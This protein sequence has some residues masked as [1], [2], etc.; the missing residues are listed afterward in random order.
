MVELEL[1]DVQ[2]CVGGVL[3]PEKEA[4]EI[5][6]FITAVAVG[7]R[8]VLLGAGGVVLIPAMGAGVYTLNAVAGVGALALVSVVISKHTRAPVEAAA[9]S[10]CDWFTKAVS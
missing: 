2:R 6:N 10:F 4:Q 9:Q 7:S 3:D 1:K 5:G 8:L